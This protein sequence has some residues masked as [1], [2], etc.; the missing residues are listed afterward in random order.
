[1]NTNIKL[2]L[3]GMAF[4]LKKKD[5][6]VTGADGFIG[7]HLVRRLLAEGANVHVFVVNKNKSLRLTDIS[8]KLIF[9]PCDITEYRSV[10]HC[11]KKSK[12]EI[13]FHLAALRNVS[14]DFRLAQ[15]MIDVNIRGTAN[16]LRAIKEE[17]IDLNC[18]IN[19][20]T[21][22]EYGDGRVPFKEEQREQPISPY[23]ASKV[24]VTHLCQMIAKTMGLPIMTLRLFL[25]YGPAQDE[26][27]FVPSLIRHCL[28]GKDF[29]MTSGGQA[30]EF[31]YVS[32]IIDA[33]V[34]SAFFYQKAIGEVINIGSGVEY[35]IVDV[36]RRIIKMMGSP[37]KLLRGVV[38]QRKG[39]AK[40]FFCSNTKAR[41]LLGWR[42]KVGLKEGLEKTIEWYR[43]SS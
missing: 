24:A 30:R 3:T 16:F 11:V 7:S 5:V 18:F 28:K 10:R 37:I 31:I 25:T 12:P 35:R 27:L 32:D 22:E 26:D 13:I 21:C 42:P 43:N 41:K 15:Q 8:E 36:A 33:Y 4:S 38:P 9:W 1:M 20:G 17:N 2:K 19:T 39:E 34:A 40:H 6:L 23:S 29:P 14:R